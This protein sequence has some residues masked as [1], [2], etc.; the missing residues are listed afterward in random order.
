MDF[1]D[2]MTK[3]SQEV[4]Q[5]EETRM[6]VLGELPGVPHTTLAGVCPNYISSSLPPTSQFG[7]VTR[8]V[9]KI[10]PNNAGVFKQKDGILMW[11]Q[12]FVQILVGEYGQLKENASRS[13]S[14]RIKRS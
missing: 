6:A 7:C 8:W 1:A 14:K 13:I 11:L 10:K 12:A 2:T 4:L 5:K 3:A 9:V